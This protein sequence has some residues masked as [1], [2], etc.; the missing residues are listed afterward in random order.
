MS[1]GRGIRTLTSENASLNPY[2]YQNGAVWPHD[3]GLIALGFKRYGHHAEASRVAGCIVE[4][5]EFF[6]V[7]HHVASGEKGVHWRQPEDENDKKR[8]SKVRYF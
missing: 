8:T 7:R 5:G 4:A 1:S 6:N 3:N 2:E